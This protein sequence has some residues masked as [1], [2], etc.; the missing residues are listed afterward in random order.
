MCG[1][2]RD[3][4]WRL[5]CTKCVFKFYF[6]R[7]TLLQSRRRKLNQIYEK[8]WTG[9]IISGIAKRYG[10]SRKTYCE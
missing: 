1:D 4:K 10:V 7:V 9:D 8:E 6:K 3:H 5:Q 2:Y